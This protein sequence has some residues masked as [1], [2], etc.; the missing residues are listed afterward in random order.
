MFV[1]VNMG[2]NGSEYF[3]MLL[4]P[5]LWVFLTKL[6]LKISNNCPH[7]ICIYEFWGFKF[8][9][10]RLKFSLAIEPYW[11]EHFKT[12]LLLSYDYFS[13]KLFLN[14]P[15]HS[16]QKRASWN[17]EISNLNLKASL[18]LNIAPMKKWKIANTCISEMAN[19]RAKCGVNFGT[20]VLVVTCIWGTFDLLAFKVILGSFSEF[21]SKWPVT[22]KGLTV[23]QNGVK[24]WTRGVVVIL[25]GGTFDLLVFSVIW[26]HSVHCLKMTRFPGVTLSRITESC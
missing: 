15:C 12:L 22:R 11:N 21:L 24:F 18:K 1:F 7:K 20:Q 2:P 23:D 13:T 19:R 14:V 17:F 26:G 16:P 6:F 10:K 4:H 3:K 5:Q 25:Y 9:K 8:K